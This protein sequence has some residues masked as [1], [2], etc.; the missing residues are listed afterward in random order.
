MQFLGCGASRSAGGGQSF[1]CSSLPCATYSTA[2]A[3]VACGYM[4]NI[5][6]LCRRGDGSGKW[7][8]PVGDA[9]VGIVR[10]VNA[11]GDAKL[12][13]MVAMM[14]VDETCE[15]VVQALYP[16]QSVGMA[17]GGL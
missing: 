1:S 5:P 17:M 8:V 10:V 15:F 11:S 9:V 2:A 6:V 3:H 16:H 12:S 7:C 14:V 13:C 4:V